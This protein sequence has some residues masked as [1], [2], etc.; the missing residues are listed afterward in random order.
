[1]Y[2]GHNMHEMRFFR[3][4]ASSKNSLQQLTANLFRIS[5]GAFLLFS[6]SAHADTLVPKSETQT[7]TL[8]NNSEVSVFTERVLFPKATAVVLHDFARNNVHLDSIFSFLRKTGSPNF[9][10]IKVTGSYSP[11]GENSFNAKLANARASALVDLVRKI[12][13]EVNPVTTITPPLKGCGIDYRQ[14]RYAE[15][16]IVYR[17][18][19]VAENI[20]S[21]S[22]RI[23]NRN[24]PPPPVL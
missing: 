13:P 16:H 10:N 6:I 12:K 20:A 24:L 15:L 17:N 4:F 21:E 19:T 8:R 14:L 3:I 9:L 7:D 1:M 5:G 23:V 2:R 22:T 18:N 11:E